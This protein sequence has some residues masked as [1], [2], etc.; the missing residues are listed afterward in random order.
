MSKRLLIIV[1]LGLAAAGLYF[2]YLNNGQAH[3][4]A[5]AVVAADQAGADTTAQMTALRAYVA[6]HMGA[7]AEV[8]LAASYSRA[9]QAARAAAA[10]QAANS[11][12]YADAQRVCGG[13]R[14]S[15]TQ[16]KCQQ[17]YLTS[18]LANVPLPTAVPEP[19]LAD[20]QLKLRAP[21]WTP[22]LAGACFLGA[23]GALGFLGWAFWRRRRL[24]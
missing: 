6:G 9:Q 2:A 10:A 4:W 7:G 3:R 11:Q 1:A 5:A 22:D 12:I 8:S 19:K 14:D 18:H 21:W 20:Y 17:D 13:K 23:A 15:I 24:T 16:A